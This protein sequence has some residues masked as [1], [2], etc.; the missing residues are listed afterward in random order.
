MSARQF[1]I[2]LAISVITMKMQKLP[3]L[4]AGELGKDTWLF[5][6]IY[7]L[8]N[9]IGIV[10]VFFILRRLDIKTVLNQSK[11]KIFNILR[12]VL[13][14]VTLLYFLVQAILVY[15]HIQGLFANTLFD[16]LSWPFFSLLLLFAVFFLAHRGVE[17]LALNYELYTWIIVTSL[18]LL[19]IFGATQADYSAILPLET[20]NFKTILSK[21]QMFSCWFGDFFLVLYLGI[22]AKD[23]KLSKTLF[24]YILSMLF[25]AFLVVIFIGIY[26]KVAPIAPGLISVISEQSLLDLSIGRLDWFLIL[27]AEMGAILTCGLNLYF[28]N[29]CLHSAF[30][31]AKAF[32]LKIFNIIV[33][34]ILDI[35]ILVDL[36]AKIKFF[37]NFMC[38][39]T[40]VVSVLT[41]VMLF[42]IIIYN[43]VNKKH[44]K[45]KI[46][47]NE[48]LANKP[49][50][51]NKKAN[52]KLAKEGGK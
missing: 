20:I 7:A 32:Y 50:I 40:N 15:E 31:K 35:F 33:L 3:P 42:G 19:S 29:L 38:Y 36:N 39:V 24:V 2:I 26:D 30:P 27:F 11:N 6:L 5:F 34:Y 13:M 1:Y 28:A 16:S 48:K 21:L 10:L 41:I 52:R 25:V 4:V 14:I 46:I 43:S 44:E 37:C 47:L 8:I 12:F 18:V 49:A 45:N 51:S 23:I 17:N 22:K 9:I